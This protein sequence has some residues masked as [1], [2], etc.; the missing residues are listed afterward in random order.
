MHRV[1]DMIVDVHT[2]VF[3]PETDFG[4]RLLAD[5][6][7]CGV[8]PAAWGDVAARHLETT[9]AADVSVVFGIQAAATGW[10]VPNDSWPRH[11]KRRADSAGVLRVH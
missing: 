2:H 8:D 3:R 9:C 11:V 6:E 1:V 7:R 5:L 4:P 10:H